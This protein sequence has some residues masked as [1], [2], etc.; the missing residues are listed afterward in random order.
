MAT[1]ESEIPEAETP[2]IEDESSK[3]LPEELPSIKLTD[4]QTRELT[5]WLDTELNREL[6][7]RRELEKEWEDNQTLYDAVEIPE[8]KDFPFKNAANL[9]IGIIAQAVE[10]SWA[11]LLGIVGHETLVDRHGRRGDEQDHDDPGDRHRDLVLE[12]THRSGAA[13]P[14]GE[15]PGRG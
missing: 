14:R 5:S 1:L 12:V 10:E 8:K 15:R 9:M 3:P 6:A 4:D 13:E 2:T 7:N 11:W